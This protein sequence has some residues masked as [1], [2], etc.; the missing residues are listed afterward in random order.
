MIMTTKFLIRTSKKKS[1]CTELIYLP[2]SQKGVN[3]CLKHNKSVLK[4]YCNCD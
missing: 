4:E 3:E 2:P 1:K